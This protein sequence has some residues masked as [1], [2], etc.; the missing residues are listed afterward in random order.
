MVEHFF[1]PAALIHSSAD[2]GHEYTGNAVAIDSEHPSAATF[3]YLKQSIYI[4]HLN[5]KTKDMFVITYLHK[6]P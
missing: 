4:I 2:F 6:M 1:F 3:I 5:S